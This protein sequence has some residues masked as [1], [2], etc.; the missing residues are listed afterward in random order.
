[1]FKSLISVV[2]VVHQ[3]LIVQT[4]TT[5]AF[6]PPQEYFLFPSSLRSQANNVAQ[7]LGYEAFNS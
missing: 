1:M 2:A 6:S 4:R 7:R 3:T 5:R